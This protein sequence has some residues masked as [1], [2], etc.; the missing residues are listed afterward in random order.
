MLRR[1]PWY[2]REAFE[3][4]L[5]RAGFEVVQG[6][7][8]S[9]AAG[10]VLLIWNRY[11][12]WHEAASSFERGGGTVLVA[13]NGYLGAGGSSPKFDVHPGGP[14]PEHYYALGIGWHNGRGRWAAGGPERLNALGVDLKPWRTSGDHILVCPNRSFGV[15]EQVMAVDW[16][17]RRAEQLRRST[18]RPV[19][20]RTHPGNDAP[21][22]GLEDDLAGAWAVVV[23]S[24][25]VAQH[26]LAAGIPTFIDAPWQI[27]K[28]AGASGSVD[29]PVTPDRR[30]AFERM[31]WAQFRLEEIETG[32]PF[33]SCLLPT[34]G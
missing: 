31:A 34:T 20:I 21:R 18:A 8:A 30:S 10:D 9:A 25:S 16:A 12:H 26:A 11:R 32:E 33:R 27:V 5:A 1:D 28:D 3:R 14:R 17:A 13:E 24:S 23:W 22:R 29:A 7:P 6:E 4:G 19:R 15:G 2:R